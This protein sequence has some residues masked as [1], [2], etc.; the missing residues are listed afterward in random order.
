MD[1]DTIVFAGAPGRYT[2]VVVVGVSGVLDGDGNPVA[3]QACGIGLCFQ[4]EGGGTY[5]LR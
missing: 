5:Q 3:T 2:P 4:A 1:G